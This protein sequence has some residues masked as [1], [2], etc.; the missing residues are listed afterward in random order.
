M[1]K[2]LL[3]SPEEGEEYAFRLLGIRDYTHEEM[4]QKLRGKGLG[5]S[6]A[7]EILKKLE[8][9]GLIDDRRYARRLAVHYSREKLWGPQ[10]VVHK[11]LQRGI[12]LDLAKEV[13]DQAEEDGSSRERLQKV[14]RLKLKGQGLEEML[15]Q[16]KR[17]LTRYLRQRGFFW[18]DIMEALQEAGGSIEE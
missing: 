15:P 3:K 6:E 17:R 7:G 5:D 10:Q 16:E 18:E 8:G 2:K 4:R 13:I 9:R 1:P 11:L 14:L 12:A